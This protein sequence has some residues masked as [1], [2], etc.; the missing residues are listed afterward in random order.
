[1]ESLPN[2]HFRTE[3]ELQE[4]VRFWYTLFYSLVPHDA[5]K[6]VGKSVHVRYD[7]EEVLPT[8]GFYNKAQNKWLNI[9]QVNPSTRM[10]KIGGHIDR[11]GDE[12]F[13]RLID[14]FYLWCELTPE[15]AEIAKRLI[16]KWVE[17]E[18]TL[19]EMGKFLEQTCPE[20]PS[21]PTNEPTSQP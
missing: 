5:E 18:T 1:M 20:P 9:I 11:F 8:V 3:S 2:Y 21:P 17:P 4:A 14:N 6:W 12:Y 10:F 16:T 15:S 7:E 19:D 13:E